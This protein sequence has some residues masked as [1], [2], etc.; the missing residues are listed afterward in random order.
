LVVLDTESPESYFL[1]RKRRLDW[2]RCPRE[3][4]RAG[5]IASVKVPESKGGVKVDVD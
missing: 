2:G 3:S 4:R 1:T 5:V